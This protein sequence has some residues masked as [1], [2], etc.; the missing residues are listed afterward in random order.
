[1]EAIAAMETIAAIE[2]IDAIETIE[3]I[4][5]AKITFF[6]SLRELRPIAKSPT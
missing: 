5:S 3:T 4:G 2:T 6:R 1:M